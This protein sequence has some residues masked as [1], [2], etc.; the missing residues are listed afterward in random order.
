MITNADTNAIAAAAAAFFNANPADGSPAHRFDERDVVAHVVATAYPDAPAASAYVDAITYAYADTLHSTY[1][2]DYAVG[3]VLAP[4]LWLT[5]GNG[6]TADV[7]P[8]DEET[9]RRALRLG[10]DEA[11]AAADHHTADAYASDA[12][13]QQRG[14]EAWCRCQ[15]AAVYAATMEQS[16]LH[17]G[18]IT[19]DAT[20]DARETTDETIAHAIATAATGD[21]AEDWRTNPYA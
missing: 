3:A 9:I 6:S 11:L 18:A 7:D 5:F 16:L 21:P 4:L 19:P 1:D 2:P 17:D 8:S 15:R 13:S 14:W 10:A 12:M 20:R